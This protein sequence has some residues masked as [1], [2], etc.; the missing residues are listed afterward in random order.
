MYYLIISY[1]LLKIQ[2]KVLIKQLQLANRLNLPVVIHCREAYGD[3]I[4]ILKENKNLLSS[5]GTFHCYCGSLEIAQEVIKLGLYISVGGVST[6]KNSTRL[7]ETIKQIPLEKIILETD[8]PYLSPHPFRGKR[9]E[10]AQVATIAGHLA[11]LKG[12]NLEEI[13]KVTS[14]NARRLFGI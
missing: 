10:P 11:E 3:M 6:F 2:K 9:N 7:Q 5:S 4:E 13:E 8:C 1:L 12:T 14:E